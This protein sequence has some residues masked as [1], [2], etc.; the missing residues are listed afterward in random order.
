[1]SARLPTTCRG[2]T[3]TGARC[4]NLPLMGEFFCHLHE[5]G[6]RYIPEYVRQQVFL[7]CQ[8]QC[9]YCRKNLEF[10]WHVDHLTPH[11]QGGSNEAG[12]LVA[13]CAPCN[14]SRGAK[15][16]RKFGEGDRRC[17]GFL[18]DGTRCT[19]QTAPGRYKYCRLHAAR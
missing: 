17:E 1:M 8:G 9:F 6:S 2:E 15:A 14:Q 18:P 19:Y 3:I 7:A 10:G 5:P 16:I 12:N 13:A 4:Q 11:S